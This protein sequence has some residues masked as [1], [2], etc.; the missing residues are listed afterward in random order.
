MT[1]D[2]SC[3]CLV[4]ELDFYLD[5]DLYAIDRGFGTILSFHPLN[6]LDV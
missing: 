1:A 3:I 2:F 4:C 6:I 5:G